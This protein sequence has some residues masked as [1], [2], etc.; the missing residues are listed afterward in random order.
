MSWTQ[1]SQQKLIDPLNSTRV[2]I[3]LLGVEM[4]RTVDFDISLKICLKSAWKWAKIPFLETITSPDARIR[5]PWQNI[6]S[7]LYTLSTSLGCCSIDICKGVRIKDKS[8][9][10]MSGWGIFNQEWTSQTIT[11]QR[12]LHQVAHTYWD[13]LCHW[14]QQSRDGTTKEQRTTEWLKPTLKPQN[15]TDL[16]H[17]HSVP[18]S[19]NV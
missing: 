13:Q 6:E 15:G 5:I 18:I 14:D 2:G 10:R 16:Q 12:D 19:G 4:L 9:V 1:H 8:M 11:G 3:F 7:R 17:L